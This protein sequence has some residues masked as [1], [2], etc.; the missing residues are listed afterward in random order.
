MTQKL[1]VSI[2]MFILTALGW[3]ISRQDVE[4]VVRMISLLTPVVLS[5]ILF[6]RKTKA[7]TIKRKDDEKEAD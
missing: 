5:I 4:F 3:S 1:F 7:D 6:I 2:E